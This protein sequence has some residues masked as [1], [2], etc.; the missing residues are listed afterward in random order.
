M[1]KTVKKSKY[2]LRNRE[3]FLEKMLQCEKCKEW[4]A[5]DLADCPFCSPYVIPAKKCRYCNDRVTDS[6]FA[7]I[8]EYDGERFI[9]HYFC[10]YR[11]LEKQVVE[12][13]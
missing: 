1:S 2:Y 8:I 12:H 5:T 10:N 6:K 9:Q 3:G 4:H 11:C 13:A 7:K